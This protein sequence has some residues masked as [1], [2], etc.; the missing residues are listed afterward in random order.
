M[1][2]NTQSRK[3]ATHKN[4]I[5][6]SRVLMP[7]GWRLDSLDSSEPIRET[8]VR[9][10]GSLV[11]VCPFWHEAIWMHPSEELIAEWPR[12]DSP[13]GYPSEHSMIKCAIP[14]CGICELI[15]DIRTLAMAVIALCE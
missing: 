7:D 15:A 9:P 2:T 3:P 5:S 14:E 8:W 4:R 13:M 11:W 12:L 10:D 6:V 1:R